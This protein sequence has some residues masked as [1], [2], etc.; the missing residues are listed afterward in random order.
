MS[1]KGILGHSYWGWNGWSGCLL[2]GILTLSL[3]TDLQHESSVGPYLPQP[4]L[5]IGEAL[6]LPAQANLHSYSLDQWCYYHNMAI[7]IYIY[8]Y[9]YI[10]HARVIC[11]VHVIHQR[12]GGVYGTMMMC[13]VFVKIISNHQFAIQC[14]N[15]LYTCVH[16]G[17]SNA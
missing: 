6:P 14:V 8:I 15:R 4:I 10:C 17:L 7:A 1:N 9:I 5:N 3:Q 11:W 13:L 2:P 16:K 12:Y